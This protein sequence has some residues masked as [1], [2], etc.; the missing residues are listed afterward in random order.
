[1]DFPKQEHA[2]QLALV[3]TRKTATLGELIGVTVRPKESVPQWQIRKIVSV[4]VELSVRPAGTR[5]QPAW[6]KCSEAQMSCLSHRLRDD[7]GVQPLNIAGPN[8]AGA[9][10]L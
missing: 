6:Y 1:M 10:G 3:V 8:C 5:P 7:H 9:Q 2:A 4:H